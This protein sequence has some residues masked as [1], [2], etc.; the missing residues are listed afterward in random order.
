MINKQI[1]TKQKIGEEVIVQLHPMVKIPCA[2]PGDTRIQLGS[3][4]RGKLK[5]GG[6]QKI[7]TK[8]KSVK[9]S[10]IEDGTEWFSRNVGNKS[11]LYAA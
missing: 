4:G 2:E 1:K 10:S 5:E 6:D 11:P 7:R 3:K 8:N 9:I